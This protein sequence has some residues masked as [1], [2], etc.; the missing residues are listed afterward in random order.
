MI[1]KPVW[2]VVNISTS[3]Q[4]VRCSSRSAAELAMKILQVEH[5]EES[6]Q[7]KRFRMFDEGLLK[8]AIKDG[9]RNIAIKYTKDGMTFTPVELNRISWQLAYSGTVG[10]V[11]VTEQYDGLSIVVTNLVHPAEEAKVIAMELWKAHPQYDAYMDAVMAWRMSDERSYRL[12]SLK[13]MSKIPL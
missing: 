9:M 11:N 4:R 8:R 10:D 13:E 3:T 1:G 12:F 5:P 2:E 7:I 6:F